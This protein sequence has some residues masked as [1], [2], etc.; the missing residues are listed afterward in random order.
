[1][2]CEESIQRFLIKRYK[3]NLSKMSPE[4]RAANIQQFGPNGEKLIGKLT[5][6]VVKLNKGKKRV[7]F[8]IDT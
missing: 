6:A 8:E 2:T 7:D 5:N 1:M 4:C 3:E